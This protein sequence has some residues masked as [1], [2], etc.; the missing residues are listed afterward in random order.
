[1]FIITD[2]DQP[3]QTSHDK[4]VGESFR[5]QVLPHGVMVKSGV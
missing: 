3:E 1:L 4:S 2:N 5:P